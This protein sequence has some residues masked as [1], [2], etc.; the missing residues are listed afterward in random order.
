VLWAEDFLRIGAFPLTEPNLQV[1][2]SWEYAESGAGGGDWNP[3][4]T[5]QPWGN[6]TNFNS[7]GVKNYATRDDGLGANAMVIHNGLYPRVVASLLNGSSALATK[8]A[9]ESSPWGTAFINLLP[10]P[11]P[12]DQPLPGVDTMQL[13]ASPHKPSVP[14][15]SPAAVW[16]PASPNIVRLT[17]GASIAGDQ[18]TFLERHWIPPLPPGTVGVGIAA[19]VH[20]SGFSKG[21]PDGRGI[22]IQDDHGDTYVGL[23]S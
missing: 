23:W 9:I 16:D 22:F 2:Y 10:L 4:N 15:R 6:S 20:M 7:V 1:V 19:T 17:N 13:V 11:L 18:A 12:P 3:L 5:T 8:W 21:Q 14:G